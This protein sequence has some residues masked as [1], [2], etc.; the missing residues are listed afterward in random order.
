[1]A[2]GQNA[3][4]LLNTFSNVLTGAL[5]N[6]P[7][8]PV[9]PSDAPEVKDIVKD[10]VQNSALGNALNLENTYQSRIFWGLAVGAVATILKPFN[11]VPLPEQIDQ[12]VD[13]LNSATI[14]GG[15]L[16]AAYGRF[17]PGLK[18]LFAKKG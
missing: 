10:V 11:I 12:W 17:W 5:V 15:L 14:L 3:Q 16:Y 6:A 8:V 4:I 7:E 1:M 9:K 18:P 2:N 13:A